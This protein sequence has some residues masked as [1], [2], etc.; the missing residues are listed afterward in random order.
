MVP[1]LQQETE[2]APSPSRIRWSLPTRI[3]FRFV[4][5]Y[6]FLYL[7]PGAVGSLGLNETV[8]SYHAWFSAFWQQVV[9][10]AGAHF[11]GLPAGLREIPNG[12][13]DQLYDY[14][15]ILCIFV[16][17]VIIT[18]V[19]SLLDRKRQNYEQL[20]Q[21]FRLFLR[22]FLASVMMLYGASKLFPMQ[23]APIPLGRLV[24][25]L[26]R[27]SPLGLLWGFMGYS[28]LY[29]LFGGIGEM[30]GGILLIVPRFTTLGALVSFA[31][32]SNVLMLNLAYD[33]PRKIFTIHLMIIAALLILPA[34]KRLADFFIFNRT[35]KPEAEAPFMKDKL[36]NKGVFALQ[37]IYAIV[38]LAI[39]LQVSYRLSIPNLAEVKA[40]LRG[41][42]AVDQFQI[43]SVLMPPDTHNDRRWHHVIFDRPDIFTI[44]PSSGGLQI[45]SL[46]IDNSNRAFTSFDIDNPNSKAS[47]TLVLP[48]NDHMS[49]K[50]QIGGQPVSTTLHRVDLSNPTEFLL[51]N[52]G[53][54]WV[55]PAPRWR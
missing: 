26:G 29:T 10:W 34:S 12:S 20:Y 14:V 19:W 40:P 11:L 39:A 53:F 15:L 27:L 4:L 24:D 45:F 38:T 9:P 32:L 23:F 52:R 22:L 7:T 49:M 55:T 2:I 18:V 17:A 31:V 51:L 54:H 35:V 48:D 21:W 8:T 36:I 6:F 25:P 47:F 16:T 43:N 30:L 46:K 33:V 3:G 41:V 37:Y 1:Q 50:G 13:G 28:R 44:Q 42:W 5:S